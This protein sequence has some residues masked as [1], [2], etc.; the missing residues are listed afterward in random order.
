MTM[1]ITGLESI[2][3]R[4]K[5]YETMDDANIPAIK[6]ALTKASLYAKRRVQ[7]QTPSRAGTEPVRRRTYALTAP[8]Y[9]RRK[10]IRTKTVK[11]YPLGRIVYLHSDGFYG[12][13]VSYGTVNMRG[14]HFLKQ[15]ISSSDGR[16][17]S[18]I[19]VSGWN[20]ILKKATSK[21]RQLKN[22]KTNLR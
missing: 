5:E 18:K 22:K 21:S 19:M 2:K 13:M 6:R 15:S 8:G 10:G 17:I 4:L 11:G 12:N 16:I 20:D 14:T 9:L 1:T 7:S 3:A